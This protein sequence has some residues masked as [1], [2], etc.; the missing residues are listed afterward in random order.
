M[1]APPFADDLPTLH[2]LLAGGV[3]VAR[4]VWQGRP[5]W[6]KRCAPPR[7][8]E[9]ALLALAPL[10]RR[11]LAPGLPFRPV[12]RDST[13]PVEAQR[14]A[15]L[16][17]AGCGVP[18][19][20]AAD[21]SLLVI[22]DCGRNLE[23]LLQDEP[24]PQLRLHWLSEAATDLGRFHA[25]GQWHGGA[26]VRNL[27]RRD[28]GSLARNDFETALDAH[29][30]LPV[31]QAIDAALFFGSVARFGDDAPAAEVAPAYLEFAPEAT[32]AVLRRGVPLLGAL[33][34]SRLLQRFAPKEAARLRGVAAVVPLL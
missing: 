5:A 34:R 9:R 13:L 17:R 1:T 32:R 19:L 21:R 24:R 8:H 2:R 6:A 31:L 22:E 33:A 30:P 25:A 10:L 23:H 18:R 28:D 15:E 3:P 29:F 11:W 7:W 4:I 27:L 20:I 16:Q 12:R 14:L 26:Q